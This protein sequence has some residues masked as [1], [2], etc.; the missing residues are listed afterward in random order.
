MGLGELKNPRVAVCI[1]SAS[2]PP[3]RASTKKPPTMRSTLRNVTAV[4]PT[5]AILL[6]PLIPLDETNV[7]SI[8][9]STPSMPSTCVLFNDPTARRL[10][11]SSPKI[12]LE[13]GIHILEATLTCQIR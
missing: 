6:I 5:E 4:P 9:Q 13:S 12:A 3:L 2:L 7:T 1:G 10:V 11:L 8:I